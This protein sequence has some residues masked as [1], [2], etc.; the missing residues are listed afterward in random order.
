[1]VDNLEEY[2]NS[3]LLERNIAEFY[4]RNNIKFPRADFYKSFCLIL[5]KEIQRTYVGDNSM[6]NSDKN[7]HFKWVWD[8]TCETYINYGFDFKENKLLFKYLKSI[9]DDLFYDIDDK[10]DSKNITLFENI[11][12]MLES[13]FNYNILKSQ[14]SLWIFADIYEIFDASLKK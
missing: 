14:E 7:N 9:F 6:N 12:V 5:D 3:S 8:K 1:M 10:S 11:S 4:S 13:I 2:L